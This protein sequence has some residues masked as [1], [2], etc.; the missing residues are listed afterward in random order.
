MEERY[1]LKSNYISVNKSYGGSQNYFKNDKGILNHNRAKGG[2]GVVAITD[3]ILYLS[4]QTNIPNIET[5]K[6]LFKAT[7]K[8]IFWIPVHFGIN[9]IQETLGLRFCLKK[10]NL[11]RKC[12][13]CFSLKKMQKRIER[14]LS[15]DTPVILC[16]PKSLNFGIKKDRSYVLPFYDENLN[17]ISGASGH[18]VVITGSYEDTTSGRIYLSISSWGRKFYIGLDEY[19]SYSQTTPFKILGNIMNIV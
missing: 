1:L 14:M 15:N 3:V 18:Y 19:I 11:N 13:W 16:V 4:E 7:S 2:C 9:F 17:I 6:A 5:Y 12:S 10:H 8:N